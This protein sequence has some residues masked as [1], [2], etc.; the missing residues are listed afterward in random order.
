MKFALRNSG[1][2]VVQR[3]GWL[4]ICALIIGWI[5]LFLWLGRYLA[6][7]DAW[8]L[9]L[10]G[11]ALISFFGAL[12]F[13]EN[14]GEEGRMRSAITVSVI[15]TY[16]TYLGS[17]IYLVPEVDS[18]GNSVKTFADQMLPSLTTMVT[19]VLSFY[20]GSSAAV[21]IADLR[22]NPTSSRTG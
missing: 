4:T 7:R 20:V 14:D 21:K 13:S 5:G 9:M 11:A 18:N 3:F 2:N 10:I 1:E 16:V 19:V 12:R 22:N 17:V 15:V 8:A 6:Y